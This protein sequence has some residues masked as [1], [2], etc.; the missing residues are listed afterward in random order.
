M[1]DPSLQLS[2]ELENALSALATR[3]GKSTH[4]LINQAVQ[5]Y[6]DR[7]QL[8]AKRQAETTDALESVRSGQVVDAET[9]HAWMESWNT[10]NELP[11]PTP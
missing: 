5:E 3:H 11:P 10:P 8:E 9:V 4:F 2:P 6:V 7:S 1:V